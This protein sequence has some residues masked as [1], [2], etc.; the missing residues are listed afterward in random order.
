MQNHFLTNRLMLINQCHQYSLKCYYSILLFSLIHLN[1]FLCCC[2]EYPVAYCHPSQIRL[3]IKSGTPMFTLRC[4]GYE[5]FHRY[6]IWPVIHIYA[7]EVQGK[8]LKGI[9]DILNFTLCSVT[10]KMYENKSWAFAFF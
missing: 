10:S 2:G 9:R 6:Q 8:D 3:C 1:L 5:L 7:V 4:S